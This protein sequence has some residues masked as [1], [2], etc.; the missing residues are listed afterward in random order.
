MNA[1]VHIYKKP[2]FYTLTGSKLLW[3]G[4]GIPRDSQCTKDGT[5]IRFFRV[6]VSSSNQIKYLYL[7]K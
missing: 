2:G 6:L 1:M 5:S 3:W 4:E 7:G